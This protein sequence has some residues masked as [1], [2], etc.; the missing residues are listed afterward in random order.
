M[1]FVSGLSWVLGV[2]MLAIVAGCG[3]SGSPATTPT[4]PTTPTPTPTPTASALTISMPRGAT[5]QTTA[6]YAPNPATVSAGTTVTWVNNDTDPHT[7]TSSSN[8]WDSGTMQPGASFSFT[9]QN[10]G[11]FQYLC[12]IHPNMVGTIVVQ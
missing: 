7:T 1:R 12:L 5:F 2:M 11:T 4:T 3:G 8:V 6:A 10:R 9:L